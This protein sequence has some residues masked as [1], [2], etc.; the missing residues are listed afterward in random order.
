MA[1]FVRAS[2]SGIRVIIV[3]TGFA[4]LTAAIECHRKGHSVIVLE[5]FTE[6]KVL[7][8]VISFGPNSGRIFRGWP[9]MEERLDPICHQTNEIEIRT[10][11]GETILRQ[12]WKEK[13]KSYG[14][15]YN[16]H[17]GQIHR[18]V[19]DY[20]LELGIDIRLGH[21]VVDYF[22][23]DNEAGVI[24]NGKTFTGDVVLAA[25]GVRSKG[26]TI[27]LGYEDKP[28]ASGYAVYR[29]WFDVGKMAEDPDF[30]FLFENQDD[31]CC[32]I[33]EQDKTFSALH[34]VDQ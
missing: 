2:D 19:F 8:D 23:T 16:G 4:G 7:G 32:W 34:R 18:I 12:T 1:G 30:A 31:F 5:S 3:G 28:K 17:R 29:A 22:E 21:K 26:R 14:K 24:A 25:D 13:E 33:G 10:W 27:V 15:N 20:A 9:G 6:L 11:K